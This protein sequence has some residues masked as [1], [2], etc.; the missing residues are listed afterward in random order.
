MEKIKVLETIRQGKI[1][2]GESHVL[3]LVKELDKTIYEPVV[4]SFTEG[5]MIDKMLEMGIKTYVIPTDTPFDFSKWSQVKQI[6][7]TENIQL[8]HAHGTR[9]NSNVFW[10]ASKLNIPLV[11]TVHGWSFHPDQNPLIR[12]IRVSS[13]KFLAQRADVTIC[14]S[15]N[16]HR[17]A[18]KK[19]PL[20]NAAVIKYG[21]DIDNFNPDKHF[22]D[23]RAEYG[24]SPETTLVGYIV[25][26]TLQKDPFTFIRAIAEIPNSLNVKFLV[27]GDGDLK[28]AMIDLAK[29]LKVDSRVIFGSFRQDIPDVLNAVDIYCL[30]SLWE[31]LPIGLL[32]AMAMKKAIVA[33]SVDGTKEVI[34]DQQNGLLVPPQSPK[35]LAKALLQLIN[36]PSQISTFGEHAY[37]VMQTEFNVASMTRK[38]EQIYSNLIKASSHA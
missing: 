15:D 11:Y 25:R 24:I 32:E 5:P 3:D 28:P 33:T 10:A 23:V 7:K 27:I 26:V 30:P 19:F 2:G 12:Q 6:L 4:L 14:V 22:K 31:G 34:I 21:I 18:I 16:N 17:D 29:Q 20:P 1:G 38:V 13:E 9:A 8:V 35:E 36:N 37:K